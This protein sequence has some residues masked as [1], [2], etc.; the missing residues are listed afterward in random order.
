MLK[1]TNAILPLY[2]LGCFSLQITEITT[3]NGFNN[4]RSQAD[5]SITKPEA[6]TIFE[7]LFKQKKCPVI[8]SI[9]LGHSPGLRN[10]WAQETP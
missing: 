1:D 3:Q 2:F 8:N 4:G 10:P 7:D 9:L 5:S 6:S